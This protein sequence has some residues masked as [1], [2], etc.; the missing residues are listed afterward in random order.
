MEFK[1][2]RKGSKDCLFLRRW[3]RASLHLLLT[4]YFQLTISNK[5]YQTSSN[6][7]FRHVLTEPFDVYHERFVSP[8]TP[9]NRI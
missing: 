4:L 2:L 9:F 3:E 1:I 7:D 5:M 6:S 8:N